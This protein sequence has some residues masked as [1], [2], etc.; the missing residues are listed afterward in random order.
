MSDQPVA[1]SFGTVVATGCL[2][3]DSRFAVYCQIDPTE[4][5]APNVKPC[6]GDVGP[7][8]A[9]QRALLFQQATTA[10]ELLLVELVRVEILRSGCVAL[11]YRAASAIVI[12]SS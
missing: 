8:L 2:S 7:E 5:V 3:A 4:Q 11:R 10:V 12:G 6:C 1:P 9:D